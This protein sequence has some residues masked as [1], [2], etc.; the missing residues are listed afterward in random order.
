M[1]KTG[2]GRMRKKDLLKMTVTELKQIARTMKVPSFSRLV[3]SDLVD[4]IMATRRKRRT[5]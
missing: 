3:K 5:K 2:G 4:A 1:Q